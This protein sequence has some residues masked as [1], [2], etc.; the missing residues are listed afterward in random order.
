[1]YSHK[2]ILFLLITIFCPILLFASERS[3]E[4]TVEVAPPV[5]SGGGD[6]CRNENPSATL[7]ASN[8]TG[9]ITWSNTSTGNE[10]TV[11]SSGSYTATCTVG[12]ETSAPSNS[13][14]VNFM[15]STYPPEIEADG[16]TTFCEGGSVN[17]RQLPGSNSYCS[18]TL[19]WNN[20]S[21]DL[22][23][24]ITAS[25]IYYATCTVDGCSSD[26]SNSIQVTVNS[27]PEAP[28]VSGGGEFCEITQNTATL[29]ASGCT[30]GTIKWSNG[31]TGSS[32]DVSNNGTYHAVCEENGCTSVNSNSVN[33][34]FD[35]QPFT[36]EIEAGGPTT[37]CEGG[38]VEL[39][40]APSNS[41]CGA[42]LTWNNGATGDPITVSDGGL[43]YATCVDG[44]CT[45][46][47][48]NTIQVIVNA[49]PE[50]P[51]VSGGGEFCEATQ[52]TATLTA[53]GCTSG[54]I[55]WSNGGTGSSIDVSN[56]GTY[57][58]VCEENGCT[59]VNSNSVNVRFDR[60]PFTPEIEA[61]GPTTFCEGGSVE[62]RQALSNSY[63]GATLTWNN[64]ATGEPL[65]VSDADIYYATC[66][67]GACT[68]DISNT[69]QVTVNEIPNA[70][71]ISG[72]GNF[73]SP[74]SSTT[75]TATGCSGTV[76]WSDAQTG[77]SIVV[78][79]A[80]TYT[81]TCTVNGC[82]SVNS[83]SE[84]VNFLT[85]PGA[86][87]V[88][89]VGSTTF[90][91][92]E[93]VTLQLSTSSPSC[94][95]TIEWSN[96][97]TGNSIIVTSAGAYSAVC[98]ETYC[99]SG[100]SNSIDV[101]VNSIPD[102]PSISGGGNFCS[103]TTSTT[104]TASGCS[105]IITW[106]TTQTGSSI[107]V[108]TSGTYSATCTVNG[109]TSDVS[110]SVSVGFYTTPDAP[111]IEANGSTSFCQGNQ[112]TLQV[113]STS[114]SC[115]GTIE[116]SDGQTGSS[117]TVDAS[118]S[119]SAIC[120]ETY[121]TSSSSN[122]IDITVSP[123]PNA[124]SITGGGN[125]CSPTTSTTLTAS[126]CTGTIT[127][128]T[129]QTGSSIIVNTSGTYSAT[130]TVNG[131]TSDVSG[132]VNVGFY[133]T[134]DAPVIEATSSTSFCQGNQVTLQVASTSPSCVGTIEWSNGQTVNSIT[135]DAS[136]SYSAICKETYCSSSSSNSI[137]ITVSPKPNPPSITGGGNFCSP[138]N[139]TT[140]TASGCTG[141]VTWN[142][143]QTGP[144]II[145]NTS[146]S[147]SA[148][149]TVNGCTSDVSGSVSV[150]FYTTPDAPVI[151]A[152]GSTSFCKGNQVTL[153][154]ASSSP[155]CGG[156]IEWSNGQ[157]GSSITVDASGSYSA[158]CKETYCSSGNSNS[159]DITVSPKPNAPSI[160]GGGNFCSPTTS[161]ILTAT[162]CSGTVTWSDTQT[163]S[164]IVVN[165]AGTYTA[166]CAV[167][168][169]TSDVSGS[170]NVGFYTTPDAPVIEATG[171][172]SFCQG[173][174]VTLQV[175]SSSPSCGGTIEW[176]NG[177]TGNSITV[178]AS[179]S[180]SAICR[181]TY[182]SS[183]T[184]NTIQTTITGEIVYE[185]KIENVTCW[186]G[187]DGSLEILPSGGVGSSYQISW[188]DSPSSSF[189]RTD[190]LRGTYSFEIKDDGGCL[191]TGELSIT[192]PVQP[193]ASIEVTPFVCHNDFNGMI[194]VNAS[195]GTGRYYAQFGDNTPVLFEAPNQT[196]ISVNQAG[197]FD[198][199]ITD[200]NNCFV[201]EFV[202]LE[203]TNSDY[204]YFEIEKTNPKSFDSNDGSIRASIVGGSKPYKSIRWADASGQD[205]STFT[206]T[207]LVAD[208]AWS[209]LGG[210]KDGR[211]TV[212]LEDQTGCLISET[213]ELESPQPLIFSYSTTQV[214]CYGDSSGSITTNVKG[215]VKFTEG[216][217]YKY[218]W[219]KIDSFGGLSLISN[220]PG[221]LNNLKSG[222]YY[223][224]VEDKN[225]VKTGQN[226]EVQSRR[227]LTIGLL[228]K[229]DNYCS[230]NPVGVLKVGTSGGTAPY[231]VLWDD[232]NTNL[233][234][235]GLAAGNYT[236]KV[237]DEAGCT[238]DS[239]F[240][241]KNEG[242]PL[243][244]LL[245]ASQTSCHDSCDGQYFTEI[246]GG[247]EPYHIEWTTFPDS[248]DKFTIGG[249]CGFTSSRIIV[250]DDLGCSVESSERVVTVPEP[251][252]LYTFDQEV[253]PSDFTLN[254]ETSW[255][256]DYLWV[257][258]DGSEAT[259][260]VITGKG[261]GVYTLT[262][263]SFKGCSD[264]ESI[265]VEPLEGFDPY[266]AGPS[267]ATIDEPVAFVN[268]SDPYS[269]T[270]SWD[271]PA[272]ATI[273]S[274]EPEKLV[275][276]FE[277][278]G[279][280]SL[281]ANVTYGDCSFPVEKVIEITN[282][283]EP[284]GIQP[285]RADLSPT[286]I[287]MENPVNDGDIHLK[288]NAP[289][290]ESYTLELFDL[291]SGISVFEKEYSAEVKDVH[292]EANGLL[293]DK[294]YALII[295]NKNGTSAKKVI[296]R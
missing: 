21:T 32:I 1:M 76:T 89:A 256:V 154:V 130:C 46:D 196:T 229:V 118:G 122:S 87:M 25:G 70:P 119:Y 288:P 105:G 75:L 107:I 113:A 234:R 45:S 153:Q 162:G 212:T 190:L 6:F 276:Q 188:S 9:T 29:T 176:S 161:T 244:A 222:Q 99:S 90:C 296:I 275:L 277:S 18:G 53:S 140:L 247:V 141:T 73:C 3:T 98:K 10:I 167:N 15:E 195:G 294:T 146:G 180:Y 240:N 219:Y 5:I 289:D 223:L 170:V 243:N 202:D 38:S 88:E 102:A 248:T 126:G 16:P 59:S 268:I 78:N 285:F 127:W 238:V 33:V 116:W 173:N 110:S 62:L 8:C 211:F 124:P 17:L 225:G 148:T 81:A 23:I 7:T 136:G 261:T 12:E 263:T 191:S 214:V 169:C 164:S 82:T 28:T 264:T 174:Q 220:N 84:V 242:T 149:C 155:S 101:T 125:F 235:E 204:L 186:A 224:E 257:F 181:E 193:N 205:L 228:E 293:T 166:T 175:A 194:K 270:V 254:G 203:F 183:G 232:G 37:F 114:P 104:L 291:A 142:T 259:D 178:D 226:I 93:Q 156:T 128:N 79:T 284:S 22:S 31:S 258:P 271:L 236:L 85:T 86:P 77:S 207:E 177:Q 58:A 83:V 91:E 135:V 231:N 199:K 112:V 185:S 26:V 67:D 267:S 103:P 249:L 182:C 52:N 262:A 111:V 201:E 137:D 57:H 260:P 66:V 163:G 64:G 123:K 279:T 41:Y 253:C 143:T 134:P 152:T 60:Q 14:E 209:F 95:G 251:V 50:A 48:S 120:K 49:I 145:V 272:G 217:E 198:L 35:R 273:I 150:G 65:S 13:I 179:G 216:D 74:T 265:L 230:G 69:I 55:K 40:Q 227:E 43:Y 30:S 245:L 165:T 250:T 129:T 255:A 282:E 121:C 71:S 246:T 24:P 157:T 54:T 109:C 63:C 97:Q 51:T 96:G 42:T 4:L 139:S 39:S 239:T 237:Q 92:G 44:A 252:R 218:T 290:A 115:G 19:T 36:P 187:H 280:L 221:S 184:S 72:G 233:E 138:T 100:N 278:S 47:I 11:F 160:T 192:E 189:K 80:G 131:C 20:G 286:F 210:M 215:G 94:G 56:N 208:P 68:S 287:L 158:I 266:F 197:V 61:A 213:I 2:N 144:S 106:N 241:I 117:I 206:T 269:E 292:L 274:S 200:I 281:I 151:E 27:I 172:T 168:G 147:Y 171:S 295:W 283:D 133:T 159:I 108:N 132:S 34:R